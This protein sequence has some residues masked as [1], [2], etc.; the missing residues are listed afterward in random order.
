MPVGPASYVADGVDGGG[1]RVPRWAEVAGHSLWFYYQEEHRLPHVAVRGEHR[2][3]LDLASGTVLAGSL[4]LK[5]HRTI[6]QFLHEHRDEAYAAW[7]ATRRG[8]PP[9]RIQS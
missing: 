8:E 2:A 6:R 9:D 4:P 3:T 5:L 1:D 7:E